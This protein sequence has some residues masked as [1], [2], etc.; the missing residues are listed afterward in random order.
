MILGPRLIVS[1]QSYAWRGGNCASAGQSGLTHIAIVF[2]IVE[3]A[4]AGDD[5]CGARRGRRR[6][7]L[8]FVVCLLVRPKLRAS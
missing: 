5:G 4:A 3:L 1:I 8:F 6:A 2:L 7:I